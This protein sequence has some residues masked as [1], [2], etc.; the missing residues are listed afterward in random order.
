MSTNNFV[1][2]PGLKLVH[3]NSRSIY[4]KLD[5]LILLYRECD[6]ICI[7]ETWL[8]SKIGNNLLN[9]QGKSLFRQDRKYGPREARGGGV[10]IYIDSKFSPYSTIN[11]E[12]SQCN[13]DFEVLS[14]DITRPGHKHITVMCI[15][16]PPRGSHIP[17]MKF[18]ETAINKSKSELW[19]LGDFNVD[20]LNRGDVNRQKYIDLFKKYGL[21]QY[22]EKITRPGSRGGTCLDWIATNTV[23]MSH[24]G[25]SN[26][27][28]SDHTTVYAVRKKAREKNVKYVYRT[29]RDLTNFDTDRFKTLISHAEWNVF[30]NT[31]ELNVLWSIFHK[32]VCDIL[33][34]MCP[35]KRFKQ[36]EKITPWIGPE[37]YRAM[38]ERDLYIKLFRITRNNIYLVEARRSRNKVNSLIHRA[39]S[40]FIK[41]QLRQTA[42]NP[43]KFWCIIKDLLNCRDDV[44][45]NARF[46]DQNT[47]EYVEI[48][49]EANFLNE[50]FINIVNNLNIPQSAVSM[51]DVYDNDTIFSFRD[52][53]PTVPEVI[54]IIKEIDVNKSSC[55]ENINTRFCKEAMLAV[56]DKICQMMT[57]S[58]LQGVVPID[59]TRGMITVLPKEGDL[60]NPGNWRPISQT[61]IF[62]KVLEK[63]VHTRILA[64]FLDNN[65]LSK[66]QFGFL[67]GRSTQ[68]AVFELTK[69]IYSAMNNKKIFGSIC[70]DISKAFDCIDHVKLIEKLRSCGVS[71]LV[72]KWFKSYFTRTQYVK[73]NQIESSTLPVSSGIGQGTILGPLIFIFYINDVIRN[74]GDL[75]VNMYADDCLIYTTGKN[76]DIMR[77]KI[78]EGLDNFQNWCLINRLKLNARKSKSLVIG[79]KHK[80]G[81]VSLENKFNLDGNLLEFPETY[82][83]LGLILDRNMSLTPLLTK[84]K[85]TVM[86][87]IFSLIK[88]CDMITTKC[89]ITVY[90]QTILPILDY[91]GF[92]TISCN[93]SDRGDLQT[94]QNH[95]LRICYN[96][97]LRDMVSIENMHTRANLLSLEQR[98][99]K[100]LLHLMFIHKYRHNVARMFPRQT[101]AAGVYSFVRERY[102]CIKYRNSPYY[103]GSLLWDGLPINVR[104]CISLSDFKK[105]LNRIYKKYDSKIV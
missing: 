24:Y 84:L 86:S 93:I 4:R 11:A 65:I 56:P 97:R 60:K 99:Q 16:R 15:Y 77:P 103:K 27:Y 69:Q 26:D 28:M 102:N 10:C 50:Y 80:L 14:L 43:K 85:Q 17:F 19:I 39:K 48:G 95:A 89:A 87:R 2:Y 92:I 32:T 94:I 53:I 66:F 81:T 45:G 33:S 68:L 88:I 38:R 74:V 73:F 70:L 18:L 47:N 59:W 22:I 12:C 9:F 44:T 55:V 98:R 100:Q 58:L 13:R 46:I 104:S 25:T 31:D 36:R 7:T 52:N 6:I 35:L 34:I 3:L 82:N 49:S 78:Q 8:S 96:V 20:Y 29:R 105:C 1:N 101:R 72:C 71:D 5:Q 51:T 42:R 23:F 61:S 91:S 76:W 67:P 79:S 83:Y 30:D 64:Y 21:R 57:K 90:K 37:I 75:K 63:L 41:T 62:A 40:D 54:K